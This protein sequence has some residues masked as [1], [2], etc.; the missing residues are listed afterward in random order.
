MESAE[1]GRPPM[2]YTSL[3][4]VGRRDGAEGVRVVD[5]RRE[6]IHRL[7]QGELRRQLVH[8]GIVGSVKPD[9]HVLIRPSGARV[10]STLSNTFGLSLVAQ[11]AAFTWAVNFL[12]CLIRLA[13]IVHAILTIIAGCDVQPF[14][15]R[16]CSWC[17]GFTLVSREP[18]TD[19][20]LQKASRATERNGWI[21]VHLE[22][23]PGEIGFQHG[24]LLAA[25]IK[26]TLQR[27]LRR[28]DPRREEGL[29]ILPQGRRT[30][31]L[32]ARGAGVSR[33][34]ER[35]RRRAE[36][37]GRE[38]RHLGYRGA[39]RL[40]RTALLRQVVRQE[41]PARRATAPGRATIA[42]P[43]SPPAATPKT[44]R[45]VIA[46]NNWTSYSSGERWNIIFD[47]A[48]AQGQPLSSWTACPA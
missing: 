45:V 43:S 33:R 9:Q 28:D 26:D 36:G 44:A 31:V 11:P 7:H 18:Q 5:D 16:F 42:A 37:Q 47:I 21:Q 19:P 23:K 34:A 27:H 40:A 17:W 15:P 32:A 13:D 8:A 25:E 22:G 41:R 35:H 14:F 48:P 39:E 4:R 3:K 20:R 30:G 6:E 10:A 24:Y 12:D 1:I 46:H 2:A 29:G 38:A